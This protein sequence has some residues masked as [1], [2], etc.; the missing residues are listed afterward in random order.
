MPELFRIITLGCKVN[1]YESACLNDSLMDAGWRPAGKGEKA[2]ATIVNT[3]VVT[4]RAAH[5]SRQA[6]RKALRENPEGI[7]AAIGC[8]PQVFPK[9]IELIKG[10]KLIAGNVNKTKIPELLINAFN[11]QGIIISINGF[12][13]GMPF[14]SMPVRRFPGRTRAYLKI[15]DG[16]QSFCTY[17]IVPFTRGPYRSLPMKNVLSMLEAFAAEGYREVVLTGINLGKYGIGLKESIN[18]K[19]LLQ[20]IGKENLSVRIRLSSIEPMEIDD[21]LIDMVGKEE[22]IC[23]HFHIPLQ[24]GDESILKKMNRIYKARDFAKIIET[25]YARI[26]E[27][28]IGIDIMAGFP[29]EGETQHKNTLS[30]V[31]DLPV[32]YLHVFPFSPRPGTAAFRLE[33][34]VE[35]GLA[36]KRAS[37]LRELGQAKRSA[38]YRRNLGKEFQVLAEGWHSEENYF[39][40]GISDNY[41]PVIFSSSR[42]I[43][44]LIV[45]V[46]MDRIEDNMIFGSEQKVADTQYLKDL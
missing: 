22:W 35:P 28:A 20:S 26:P 5:Q 1:Q 8:Y 31:G 38:F 32:S 45:P 15:Q 17:C 46:S 33:N 13:A 3:C 39:Y 27:A 6:I 21:D 14:E 29:G 11:S 30:L 44:G 42:D 2:D 25:I 10:V 34:Q 16:C 41:L 12:E 7:T 24:S 18:L 19:G 36:K 9:E 43:K 40:K 4:R 37:E 23:R